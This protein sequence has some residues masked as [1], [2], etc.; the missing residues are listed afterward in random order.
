VRVVY[1]SAARR[2]YFRAGREPRA[3][4]VVEAGPR[5]AGWTRTCWSPACPRPAT[6]LL[7]DDRAAAPQLPAETYRAGM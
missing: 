5:P 6:C 1:T 7:P 3:R 4:P 2:E